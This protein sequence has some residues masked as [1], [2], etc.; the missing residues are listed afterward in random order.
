MDSPMMSVQDV[1]DYFQV[2]I[3][4][5]Y[6]NKSKIPGFQKIGGLIVFNRQTLLEHTKGYK[7]AK[8][9]KSVYSYSDPH[10]LL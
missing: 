6:V 10:S 2:G 9:V 1:A 3:K 4:W 5:V 7:P 8:T